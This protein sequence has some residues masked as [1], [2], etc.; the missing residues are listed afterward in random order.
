M[1]ATSMSLFGSRGMFYLAAAVSDFYVP[2]KDMVQKM[3][4][5]VLFYLKVSIKSLPA[6][7]LLKLI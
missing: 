6:H 2:W 1:V 4:I 7:I 3:K 5:Y